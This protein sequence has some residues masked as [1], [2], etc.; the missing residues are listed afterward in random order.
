MKWVCGCVS[1]PDND[2]YNQLLIKWLLQPIGKK[3]VLVS[4]SSRAA[5]EDDDDHGD[6]VTCYHLGET[7]L[8]GS[9]NELH[10][11]QYTNQVES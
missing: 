8:I 3:I 7:T 5:G 11:Y 2:C 1:G 10:A 6:D 4:I 9:A